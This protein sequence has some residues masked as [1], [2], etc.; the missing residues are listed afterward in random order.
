MKEKLS[1]VFSMA[2]CV[3]LVCAAIAVGVRGGWMDERNSI[4]ALAGQYQLVDD[5]ADDALNNFVISCYNLSVVAAR[6]LPADDPRIADLQNVYRDV[7]YDDDLAKAVVSSCKAVEASHSLAEELPAMESVK[8]NAADMYYVTK[9]TRETAEAP[10]GIVSVAAD[11]IAA[12]NKKLSGSLM[13]RLAS[14]LGV[15]PIE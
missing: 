12:F 11:K 3:V 5:A 2:L 6:H 7:A 10:G 15:R 1:S 14:L 8:N 9:L 13:G 4:T